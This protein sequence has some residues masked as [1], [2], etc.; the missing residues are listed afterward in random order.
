MEWLNYHHLFY[1]WTVARS[2][3]I[4]RASQELRLSQP[5]ISTQLRSLE[6]ALGQELFERRGRRLAL[7]DAGRTA[8]R[9][10]DDIFR[11]GRELQQAM[12]GLPTGRPR[13]TV[14]VADV[15]PKGV[16]ERLLAVAVA[17]VPGLTLAC[18]EAPLRQLLGALALHEVDVVLSDAPAGEEV[19]VRAFSHLLSDG[20]TSFLAAP[21]QARLRRGFPR[22]LD[23]APAL[24]P[25]E[26]TAFRRALEEWFEA[27]GVRPVPVGEFDDSALLTAFGTRGAGFFAVPSA[28]ERDVCTQAGV[29]P[30]GR[31]AAVRSR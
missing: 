8:Q 18:R 16:V 15:V 25:S 5:T 24:L 12:R 1:F 6:R 2:G 11:T 22:S 9:Y 10:A 23:G 27:E 29:V 21:G 26:G 13:L 4:A 17:A 31:A 19:R 30:V 20:P 3:T 7:T 14:G 28:V